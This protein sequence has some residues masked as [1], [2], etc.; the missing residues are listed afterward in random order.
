MIIAGTPPPAAS[1]TEIIR[2]KKG[3]L[4]KDEN[5]HWRLVE[6]EVA[7]ES[8]G[9]ILSHTSLEV[10]IVAN[11]VAQ[12]AI[13]LARV[14]IRSSR[15]DAELLVM[16]TMDWSRELM[17]A[18]W[19]DKVNP[20]DF[21]RFQ[22]YLRRR[23]AREPIAYI[24]GYRYFYDLKFYV[25]DRVLIP[26]PESELLVEKTLSLI[27]QRDLKNDQFAMV[28]VGTGCGSLALSIAK[29]INFIKIYATDISP[30]AIEVARI[31]AK[32]LSLEQSAA[33][34]C[35]D[36]LIPLPQPVNIIV[37]NLPYI[38]TARLGD[39]QP[40]ISKYEPVG[41][42]DGGPDGLNIYRTLLAQTPQYLLRGGKMLCE[43]D[44]EQMSAL[45]SIILEQLPQA[46]FETL[47]DLQGNE[48][49][50]IVHTPN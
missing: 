4:R 8:Q 40:E 34:L 11:I 49:G 38:P 24:L 35:G 29:H 12:S 36:L 20:A 5:G 22:Y 31:N 47:R 13:D 28:D 30:A 33:F 45:R 25:D 14:G 43:A 21:E 1:V 3:E 26:R 32:L 19:T 2:T 27:R 16:H 37:A 39:L 42:L 15:L 50:L 10:R 23:L 48:R 44:P 17:I 18:H 9:E 41:A 6:T 46:D 7:V